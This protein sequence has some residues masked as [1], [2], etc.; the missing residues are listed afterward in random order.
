MAGEKFAGNSR[1]RETPRG[2]FSPLANDSE[3]GKLGA[4]NDQTL[5]HR[6]SDPVASERGMGF[7][8]VTS[9]GRRCFR[10][11]SVV[12][13][14]RLA[15]LL[16][17]APAPAYEPVNDVPADFK[18]PQP[19][20]LEE[21]VASLKVRPGLRIE[22]VA[23][24]PLVMDPIN[25]DWGADGR[26]WVVEMADYPL[27]I[28]GKGQ[29]G[30]R[31]RFL[32]DSDGDGKYDRSKLFLDGLNF[33]TAVK[34]WRDGVLVIACPEILF[35]KDTNGDGRA[36]KI[37]VLYRGFREGNQQHRVNG[38][39][40]GLDGWLYLANGDSGGTV[41]SVKTGETLELGAFDLA[42]QPDTGAMRLETGRTQYGRVRDDEGNWFGCSNSRPIF[43]FRLSDEML[44]RNPHAVYPPAVADIDSGPDP[45][46]VFP[47]SRGGQRYN[48]PKA[49][50]RFTSACGLAIYR[51]VRLGEAFQ[52]DA[53]IC[54]P[55]HNLVSRRK[56]VPDGATF[57]AIRAEDETDS[58]FLASTDHWFRPV[59][60]K[61]GPDGGLWVVDM[62]RYVIE[63]P[64]WI[65]APWQKVLDLRAG[66]DRGRIYRVVSG[67]CG[68]PAPRDMTALKAEELLASLGSVGGWE[69]DTAQRLL[70]TMERLS[71]EDSLSMGLALVSPTGVNSLKPPWPPDLDPPFKLGGA[72]PPSFLH[73]LG[74][75]GDQQVPTEVVKRGLL[76][77]SELEKRAALRV[78]T[79]EHSLES[80]LIALATAAEDPATAAVAAEALEKYPSPWASVT[81]ADLL[82]QQAND[83]IVIAAGVSSLIP[84]IEFVALRISHSEKA[85]ALAPHV[86]ETAVALNHT[87]AIAALI[88][89]KEH[90]RAI[91]P[92][93]LGVLD[94]RN[95]DLEAFR[96]K[97]ETPLHAP[98]D[99]ILGQV[100]E[101]RSI[102]LD[103]AAE[104]TGRLAAIPLLGRLK[105]QR[106]DDLTALIT[107]LG[108]GAVPELQVAAATRILELGA[109]GSTFA[110]WNTLGPA[111]RARLIGGSLTY[112]NQVEDL[113]AALEAGQVPKTSIDAATRERLLN[114]PQS[115]F[116]EQAAALFGA[117]AANPDRA[118]VIARFAPALKEK[119][120]PARGRALFTG[121]CAACHQLG[122]IGRPFGAD[123]AA[124]ADKS[125]G[126]LLTAIL[127][128]NAAVEDK[129]LLYQIDTK[130]GEN[131]AG[132]IVAETGPAVKLLLLDGTER[133]LP[134]DQ[135]AK[136]QSI[137][138]SAMPEGLEATL[139]N[140]AMADLIA[141]IR[142][143]GTG[144]P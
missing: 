138:R 50:N 137:G 59:A 68:S 143:P 47:I 41:E 17:A 32:E 2:A 64:E 131:L 45:R 82:I 27:G 55:V 95:I 24:E 18:M 86:L 118:A 94:R 123:L 39:E 57:R 72:P 63:H 52:G 54:E 127:D 13:I 25:I 4:V 87:K 70:K 90:G 142:E 12:G 112:R 141:F 93:F 9:R 74:L 1:G 15:L 126:A 96:Q 5:S 92:L 8:P 73:L 43:H 44:R 40:W 53:F 65:P 134:R 135:I 42:I 62:H 48:D 37:E 34:P 100:R 121:L 67:N 91:V 109:L 102:A 130:N 83:P 60:A 36:D 33:P 21:S 78:L 111:V 77:Q 105:A 115:K 140:P 66:H 10:L 125:P 29:P 108:P 14:A 103:P 20:K 88:G 128:P 101:A 124:L 69:R 98:L 80:E 31:V 7:Q 116:R 22:L 132:L 107:L 6:R 85:E 56:L 110:G 58:E 61:T 136:Q 79:A 129:Y 35:A 38:L 11:T 99:R 28:D 122:G 30:G 26:L 117:E 133:D 97:A 89:S 144:Q 46:R 51:D 106:A 120:D 81:L 104:A 113:L 84:H 114:Y 19:P 3:L 76:S 16:F 139:D 119:G 71:F 49:E 75:F 23:A